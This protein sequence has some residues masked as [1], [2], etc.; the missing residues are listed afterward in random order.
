[1]IRGDTLTEKQ[2]SKLT[3]ILNGNNQNSTPATDK[4]KNYL[5]RLGY[6][7]D[8]DDITKSQASDEITKIKQEKWG[9]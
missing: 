3:T 5:K 6:D 7:G 1:M 4:Q 9:N 8:L 2:L